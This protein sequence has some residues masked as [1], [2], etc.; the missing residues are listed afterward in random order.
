MG[1][2]LPLVRLPNPY[3]PGDAIALSS[4]SGQALQIDFFDARGRSVQTLRIDSGQPTTCWDGRTESGVLAPSG[5]YFL[6][7]Q[8]GSLQRTQSLILV[9]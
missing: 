7:A 6:R 5:R 8:S 1:A 4:P 9:R 2:P 3:R